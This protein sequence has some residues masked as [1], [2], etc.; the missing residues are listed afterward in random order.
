LLRYYITDRRANGWSTATLL[1][2]IERNVRGGV[3]YI[4]IREKDLTARELLDVTKRTVEIAMGSRTRILVNDRLDIA[5]CAGA[6]GV[7]LRGDSIP[8]EILRQTFGT[9]LLIGVSCHSIEDITANQAA[10]L[11]VFGPVFESPGKGVPQGL[12]KLARAAAA[13]R[14]PVFALGGV[15]ADNAQA[16]LNAGAAGV[17][18]IRLFQSSSSD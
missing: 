18:A 5:L 12:E 17:A 4:Q 11:L 7:H 15:N 9:A 6:A 1:D 14:I 13:S 3:D 16:S 2:C 8:P 10:D